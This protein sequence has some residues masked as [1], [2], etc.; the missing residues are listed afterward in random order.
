MKG[1][2]RETHPFED[3]F[4]F[5]F[6]FIAIGGLQTFLA[7]GTET[8]QSVTEE[9]SSSAI[10]RLL[11]L[12]VV[13]GFL[14]FLWMM[15][16][17][18]YRTFRSHPVIVGLLGYCLISFLWSAE[19]AE[20]LEYGVLFAIATTVGMYFGARYST[21]G[22]L[23]LTAYV[24]FSVLVLS[25]V[26]I[27]ALPG[28]GIMGEPHVG[29]WR[30]IMGH[31]NGLGSIA[32]TGLILSLYLLARSDKDSGRIYFGFVVLCLLLLAGSQST[33]AVLATSVMLMVY[34]T[35]PL[36]QARGLDMMIL[37]SAAALL[38]IVG[39]PIFLMVLPDIVQ[40]FGKDLTLTGRLPLWQLALDSFY[41]KPL[42]GFG[43][44]AYWIT[45]GDY[46]G[47]R[48]HFL[49]GWAPS[50]IHNGWLEVALNL[51]LVGVGFL[52]VLL[53]NL[54]RL[55][56]RLVR[57]TGA[58]E[59]MCVLMWLTYVLVY[60]GAETVFFEVN[61]LTHTLMIAFVV[62]LTRE[63]RGLAL[64]QRQTADHARA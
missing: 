42:L 59:Y 27:V 50:H 5:Y 45:G 13:L 16:T 62:A 17:T 53:F 15:K 31:K 11:K 25:L 1:N 8:V 32:G 51:G 60:S 3:A 54:G 56:L 26:F 36:L 63:S 14:P 58:P 33:T 9:N 40:L 24:V 19:P 52:A 12:S 7:F 49:A 29:A 64:W 28:F 37:S 2:Y 44:G 6:L 4:V 47:L 30:G 23:R 61:S 21:E 57:L 39:V 20:T 38:L 18:L 41:A 43:F 55:V 48:L 22:I 10:L 34:F 35:W 46:G